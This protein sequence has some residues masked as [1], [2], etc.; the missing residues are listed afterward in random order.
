MIHTSRQLKDLVRNLAKGDSLQ[1]QIIMRNYIMERFLERLASSKYNR[2]FILK[3]GMLVSAMV[4]LDNRTTLDI[5]TTIRNLPLSV[6]SAENILVEI[7]SVPLDDGITFHMK[8]VSSIMD[9]A[10][11]GGIRVAMEA[12]LD[13]MK[14]PLKLDIS[15][16]DVITPR[17]VEYQFKLMFENRTISI[18]AYNLETVLAEKLETILSRDTANTRLRDFYDLYILQSDCS[19]SFDSAVL[20]AAF[21]ATYEKRGSKEAMKVGGNTLKKIRSSGEMQELWKRY[22]TKFFYAEDIEWSK[23]MDAVDSLWQAAKGV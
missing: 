6:T 17:E 14:T 4:G 3:G 22:Q 7:I 16:G 5:D 8:S 21:R 20:P 10:E 18:L 13:T 19:R 9:E 2:N 23:V 1:A 11:Y 12:T 15:T